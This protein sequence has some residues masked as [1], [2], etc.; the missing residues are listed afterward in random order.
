M[1]GIADLRDVEPGSHVCWSVAS[2]ESYVAGARTFL[3]AAAD[4]GNKPILFGPAGPNG[5]LQRTEL[6]SLAATVAD[7]LV[8][9][10]G[11]RFDADA[12][13]AMFTTE[14]QQ[15]RRDGYRAVAVMADM[16]WLHGS[17]TPDQT[18]SF[19]LL[20]DRRIKDLGAT[21]VCAYRMASFDES[22]RQALHAVHPTNRGV[23]GPSPFHL[24][25]GDVES[26][27]LGGEVDCAN[28]DTFAA[29]LAA[30]VKPERC[31]IDARGLTFIDVSGMR[32]LAR[33]SR[34]TRELRISNAPS[35]L[36][37]AWELSGFAPA[38]PSLRLA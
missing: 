21:V 4:R 35:I 7:P 18:L 22:A 9:I 8:D 36:R 3:A 1:P 32:E 15:A 25:A 37:R 20:L 14:T 11:G 5:P 26:W 33:A 10:L 29:A 24:V 13:L 16:D 38:A 31:V 27:Q 12:M 19:E 6:S 30:V 34:H 23:D 28:A 2:E 17:A